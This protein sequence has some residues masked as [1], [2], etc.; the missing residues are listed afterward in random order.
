M[1]YGELSRA[2]ENMD[3]IENWNGKLKTGNGRQTLN[4]TTERKLCT[5]MY[6]R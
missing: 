5:L 3:E 6:S 1:P 4:I 2:S